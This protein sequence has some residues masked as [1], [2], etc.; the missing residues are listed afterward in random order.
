M[1]QETRRVHLDG[2]F[3]KMTRYQAV[4]IR[5]ANTTEQ[6]ADIYT[7]APSTI[8]QW[9]ELV[10]LIHVTSRLPNHTVIILSVAI[11]SA[12]SPL[13]KKK[14]SLALSLLLSCAVSIHKTNVHVFSDSVLW[15]GRGVMSEPFV[16]GSHY[17]TKHITTRPIKF[18]WHA[19]PGATTTH[20]L[21]EN[22]RCFFGPGSGE[23]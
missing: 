12:N 2:I 9:R 16:I 18:I 23:S 15:L 3:G 4:S 5:F 13:L 10:Q 22:T 11:H 19:R 7:K 8:L 6:S 14:V 17:K 1:S 20:L 21:S